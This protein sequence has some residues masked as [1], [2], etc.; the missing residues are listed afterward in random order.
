MNFVHRLAPLLALVLVTG[1][2]SACATAPVDEDAAVPDPYEDWNRG[3]YAFNDGLDK[4][5]IAPMA[6]VYVAVTPAPARTGVGNFFDNLAYPTVI[7]N[8]F[9]QGKIEQGFEGIGRFIFNSTF[10]LGGLIDF[11]SGV[12]LE[13]HDE[14]FGQT[15]AVWGFGPGFYT[16]LPMVGPK[17]AS[18]AT[19]IPADM[20]TDVLFYASSS[21]ALPLGLLRMV[22]KR[23]RLDSAIRLR[24][25]TALDPYVFQR[26]AYLQH[27]GYLI[28][29]G[30]LP[31]DDLAALHPSE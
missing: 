29:D 26:E 15:L 1:L 18:E 27:R 5:I 22:D 16:D 24:D 10:G 23:A 13:R 7:I 25:E 14:D 30:E 6:E 20:V 2:V 9:L 17:T 11:S 31:V 28:H 3:F 21:V 4:A 19:V 8:S 12:G